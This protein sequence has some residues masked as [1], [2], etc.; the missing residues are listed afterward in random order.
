[1]KTKTYP[2]TENIFLKKKEKLG[3][4]SKVKQYFQKNSNQTLQNRNLGE[5]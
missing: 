5:N 4:F 2:H 3:I 1:M